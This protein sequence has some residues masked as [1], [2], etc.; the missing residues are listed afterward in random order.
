MTDMNHASIGMIGLGD[1][2]AFAYTGCYPAEVGP[3]LS[4][5]KVIK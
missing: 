4:R 3:W 2:L 1:P 5:Q